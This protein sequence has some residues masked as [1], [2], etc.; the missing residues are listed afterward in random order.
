MEGGGTTARVSS[1]LSRELKSILEGLRER[2]VK[3]R[4]EA[5]ERLDLVVFA[6]ESNVSQ[7][8]ALTFGVPPR[9][10]GRL[11]YATEY[12]TWTA[13]LTALMEGVQDDVARSL[14]KG[15]TPDS[16]YSRV[17][18]TVVNKATGQRDRTLYSMLEPV[19]M[20]L[21]SHLSLMLERTCAFRKASQVFN[22]YSTTLKILLESE[23]FRARDGRGG[24]S[25]HCMDAEDFASTLKPL[26][27][28]ILQNVEGS[29]DDNA[30]ASFM[31]K[32]LTVLRSVLAHMTYDMEHETRIMLMEILQRFGQN[33]NLRDWTSRICNEVL[34]LCVQTMLYFRG[35][36]I[37]ELIGVA[38]QFHHSALLLL[39]EGNPEGREAAL[40]YFRVATRLELLEMGLVKEVVDWYQGLDLETIWIKSPECAEYAFNH[41]QSLLALLLADVEVSVYRQLTR[42]VLAGLDMDGAIDAVMS[43]NFCAKRKRQNRRLG[44]DVVSDAVGQPAA[45]GPVA[46]MFLLKHGRCLSGR[47]FDSACRAISKEVVSA[48]QHSF[49]S[50]HVKPDV[51][52]ILRMLYSAVVAESERAGMDDH[53]NGSVHHALGGAISFL[54]KQYKVLS[55]Y[56]STR[57]VVKMVVIVG[58]P[59][60]HDAILLSNSTMDAES[61]YVAGH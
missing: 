49:V 51:V 33:R 41:E 9:D 39:R 56:G 21:M 15:S 8:D 57:D 37:N 23:K 36:A 58:L 7:L 53:L 4:K 11:G 13:I 38:K 42:D 45:L 59:R 47:D 29:R 20:Q 43:G 10:H 2:K 35:D 52:W 5:L 31:V 26:C 50:D 28:M 24:A 32:D 55:S 1:A 12:A 30:T 60:L 46:C 16:I 27:R 17:V 40:S 6:N 54:I 14:H 61:F 18:R 22:D 3:S 44:F 34:G 25:T 48:L 19:S